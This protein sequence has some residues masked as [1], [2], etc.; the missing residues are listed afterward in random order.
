QPVDQLPGG[1]EVEHR[2]RHKGSGNRPRCFGGRPGQP[3]AMLMKLSILTNS[4]MATNCWCFAPNSPSSSS[5]HGKS[6]PC[7]VSQACDSVAPA[8]DMVIF[9][10]LYGFSL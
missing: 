5:S 7:M 9:P 4:N 6:F 3:C 8:K 2:L 1:L 10:Y